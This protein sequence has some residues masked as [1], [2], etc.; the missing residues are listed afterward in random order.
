MN[1]AGSEVAGVPDKEE[2]LLIV[3]EVVSLNALV[4]EEVFVFIKAG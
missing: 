2:G 1:G 4:K 3:E